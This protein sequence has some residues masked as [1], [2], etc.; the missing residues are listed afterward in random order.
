MTGL[1]V[2]L[3]QDQV[4]CSFVVQLLQ[5]CESAPRLRRS[6]LKHKRDESTELLTVQLCGRKDAPVNVG[7]V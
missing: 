2:L 1:Q 4:R 3:S 6:Q 7:G 5:A